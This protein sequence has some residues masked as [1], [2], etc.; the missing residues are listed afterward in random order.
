MY[1]RIFGFVFVSIFLFVFSACDNG[2]P[3]E[4]NDTGGGIG[5]FSAEI[6]GAAAVSFSGTATSASSASSPGWGILFGAPSTGV[7]VFAMAK[8]AGSRPSNGTY[9]ISRASSSTP[10]DE[11]IASLAVNGINYA[12]KNGTL[13]ITSS[14]DTEVKG[15][16]NFL[17]FSIFDTTSTITVDGDFHA[18]QVNEATQ[19]R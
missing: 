10:D 2:S 1:T 13:T 14:S 7:S 15:A 3:D 6:T 8:N 12:S 5:T 11:Y 17:A 18:R 16:F 9:P 19:G 4:D